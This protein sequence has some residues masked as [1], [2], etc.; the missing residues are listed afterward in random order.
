MLVV[1]SQ[2]ALNTH[3]YKIISS[4]NIFTMVIKTNKT[5]EQGMDHGG[6]EGVA[7]GADATYLS[8][9]LRKE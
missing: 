6:G 3:Y 7:D 2:I 1:T 4:S 5:D 9:L 8:S